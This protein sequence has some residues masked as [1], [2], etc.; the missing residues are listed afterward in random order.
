MTARKE[1]EAEIERLE[2]ETK[3]L[4]KLL[5]RFG[6]EKPGPGPRPNTPV[7]GVPTMRLV[8]VRDAILM[9]V[10]RRKAGFRTIDILSTITTTRPDIKPPSVYSVIN[11]MLTSGQLTRVTRG[12]YMLCASNSTQNR[13]RIREI[14]PIQS[15]PATLP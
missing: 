9:A 2:L 11:K 13:A 12:H 4:K 3:T 6:E 7:P 15:E 8:S 10:K 14:T 5:V 1:I